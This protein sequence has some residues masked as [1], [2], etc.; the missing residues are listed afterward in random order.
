MAFKDSM[1]INSR[2]HGFTLEEAAHSVIGDFLNSAFAYFRNI[3]L[4][5][6]SNI[7]KVETEAILSSAFYYI[8]DRRVLD[9][10]AGLESESDR[11]DEVERE[12]AAN[13]RR[14]MTKLEARLGPAVD[15]D[16]HKCEHPVYSY[17]ALGAANFS[18]DLVLST[19]IDNVK[20]AE[21]Q[22]QIQ[23]NMQCYLQIAREKLKLEA[24]SDDPTL[25]HKI[26]KEICP[27]A[28][29]YGESNAY[30]L[31]C[32][33]STDLSDIESIIKTQGLIYE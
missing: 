9:G 27:R 31:L 33:D 25:L 1:V 12:Y 5:P 16:K 20:K 13:L 18:S 19:F 24:D 8:K 10:I 14:V 23:K 11:Y 3:I 15:T 30:K 29:G 17:D 21:F 4:H 2:K 26:K 6:T 28:A 7:P 32:G 22:K